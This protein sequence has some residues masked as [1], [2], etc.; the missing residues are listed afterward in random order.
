MI[1]TVEE[2]RTVAGFEEMT[3][4]QLTRKIEAVESAICAVTHNNFIDRLTKQKAYPPDVVEGALQM[5]IYNASDT[6]ERGGA[7]IASESLSQ[8][9][10]SYV[11]QDG[12]NTIGG[13]PAA[14]MG[15]LKPYYKARF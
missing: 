4:V 12:N 15:F 7:G 11:V 1:I 9:S 5:L 13:Y 10:V 8:H 2:L 6:R 3:D 14:L